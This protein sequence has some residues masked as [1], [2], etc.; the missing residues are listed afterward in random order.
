MLHANKISLYLLNTGTPTFE[1]F[2]LHT[3]AFDIMCGDYMPIN[4]YKKSE[5][6]KSY[7]N[8]HRD[9]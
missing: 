3:L 4:Q 9:C 1:L 8:S 7:K 6:Q 2:C 5:A